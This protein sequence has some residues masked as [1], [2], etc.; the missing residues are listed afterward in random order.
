[1]LFSFVMLPFLT[2]KSSKKKKQAEIVFFLQHCAVSIEHNATFYFAH[3][4]SLGILLMFGLELYSVMTSVQSLV[5]SLIEIL[6]TAVFF[7]AFDSD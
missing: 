5:D 2:R 3:L 1:M 7:S 4:R 6:Q